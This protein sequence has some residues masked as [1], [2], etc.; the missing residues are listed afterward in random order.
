MFDSLKEYYKPGQDCKRNRKTVFKEELRQ[1]R[2]AMLSAVQIF[3][4]Q[5]FT[6]NQKI[7]SF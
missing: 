7:S 3:N 1:M 6:L 5:I 2:E 4:N